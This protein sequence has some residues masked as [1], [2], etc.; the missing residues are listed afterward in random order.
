MVYYKLVVSIPH[1]FHLSHYHH[2]HYHHYHQTKNQWSRGCCT[3]GLV[4]DSNTRFS[5]THAQFST[6][7]LLLETIYLP[8]S[9]VKIPPLV[10]KTRDDRILK[11]AVSV[12]RLTSRLITNWFVVTRASVLCCWVFPERPGI[13]SYRGVNIDTLALGGAV[14]APRRVA[15]V[16]ILI[17]RAHVARLWLIWIIVFTSEKTKPRLGE[18]NAWTIILIAISAAAGLHPARP[19]IPLPASIITWQWSN[20]I[21]VHHMYSQTSI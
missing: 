17:T 8:L 18:R 21:F 7:L 10:S 14:A 11:M 15:T 6:V 5:T 3:N 19:D 13:S 2:H 1:F 20:L 16:Y 9:Y 4:L 12:K